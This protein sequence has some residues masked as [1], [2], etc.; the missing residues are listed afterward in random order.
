MPRWRGWS[1]ASSEASMADASALPYS[2]TNRPSA[3]DVWKW[4]ARGDVGLAIGVV[5]IIVLLILPVPP[6][7]LDIL[8]SLS[9]TSAVLILMTTLMIRK[10]LEFTAFPTVLLVTTLYRL[11][12]NIA[13]TRLILSHGHEG[14]DPAGRMI[15]AFGALMMGGNFV[16]GV[17]VFAILVIVNFVV[18]T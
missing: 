15:Q 2:S 5:G 13:S 16:I 17:I 11:G 18:I 12:L 6:F 7:L 3:R 10:P 14:G 4:V 9:I 8:L 1:S